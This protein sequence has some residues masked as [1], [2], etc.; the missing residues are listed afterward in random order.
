M[1]GL[2]ARIDYDAPDQRLGA[3]EFAAVDDALRVQGVGC[4]GQRQRQRLRRRRRIARC[5]WASAACIAASAAGAAAAAAM[6]P[7]QCL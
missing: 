7:W 6:P 5:W 3:V 4:R 1:R 2:D